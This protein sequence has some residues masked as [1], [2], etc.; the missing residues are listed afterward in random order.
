M[1]LESQSVWEEEAAGTPRL[2]DPVR[3]A[4][5]RAVLI[6]SMAMIEAVIEVLL[7]A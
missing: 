6:V 4:A 5:V 3:S 2:P 7:T 1:E